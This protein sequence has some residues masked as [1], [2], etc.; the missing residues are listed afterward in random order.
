[1]SANSY[2]TSNFTNSR[3]GICKWAQKK[4]M[5]KIFFMRHGENIANITK[6]F[7]YKNVDYSLT[8]KGILQAKQTA[9]YFLNKEIN[10]IYSS[11][12]KRAYETAKVISDY[13]NV[14]QTKQKRYK[15][16]KNN[17]IQVST[18]PRK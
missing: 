14:N 17:D 15:S 6:E 3:A 11:P 9:E 7:S 10:F 12:L 5:N 13:I 18:C 8:E 16:P 2:G 1:M 4:A